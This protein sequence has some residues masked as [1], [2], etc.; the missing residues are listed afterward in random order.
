MHKVVTRLIKQRNY[1]E[2]KSSDIWMDSAQGVIDGEDGD[3][4]KYGMD[5]FVKNDLSTTIAD[6]QH[7]SAENNNN[8]STETAKVA[9]NY[10]DVCTLG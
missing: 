9:Q 4:S 10:M 1:L 5:V 2:L 3:D 6:D 7:Q 8:V